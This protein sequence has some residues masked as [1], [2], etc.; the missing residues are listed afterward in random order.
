TLDDVF[1]DRLLDP[2]M[3]ASI[4]A[5]NSTF[6]FTLLRSKALASGNTVRSL[7]MAHAG[8]VVA[9]SL[10]FESSRRFFGHA[11]VGEMDYGGSFMGNMAKNALTFGALRSTPLAADV[12]A[13]PVN[14]PGDALLVKTLLPFIPMHLVNG[15]GHTLPSSSA[16]DDFGTRL[17]T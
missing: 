11:F 13:L 17:A 16:K 4:L 3:I 7:F 12:G 6:H 14:S 15:F 2:W 1:V 9:E 8:G 5:G 10:A